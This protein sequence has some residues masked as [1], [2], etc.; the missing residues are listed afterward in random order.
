MNNKLQKSALYHLV[1]DCYLP[2]VLYMLWW[3]NEVGGGDPNRTTGKK[4]RHSVYS[5]DKPKSNRYSLITVR[6]RGGTD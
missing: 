5:V 4:A 1:T 3:L 6:D 2:K